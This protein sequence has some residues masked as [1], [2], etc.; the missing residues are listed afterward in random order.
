MTE[1]QETKQFTLFM[2]NAAKVWEEEL[3][4]YLD[5]C[6]D[7]NKWG[8]KEQSE[9]YLKDEQNKWAMY[10]GSPVNKLEGK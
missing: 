9:K 6:T 2:K 10:Y 7:E 8:T 1:A 4:K 5:K 3:Q